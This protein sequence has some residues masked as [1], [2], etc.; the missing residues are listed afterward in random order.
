MSSVKMLDW[1]NECI[2]A[3]ILGRL[4]SI[5]TADL[6]IVT[7]SKQNYCHD[8]FVDMLNPVFQSTST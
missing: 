6:V 2:N 5:S 7:K 1:L 3:H 8:N 4:F